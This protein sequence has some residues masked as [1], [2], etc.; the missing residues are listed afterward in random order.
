[1]Q[2]AAQS[3]MSLVE[4]DSLTPVDGLLMKL[5]FELEGDVFREPVFK[6]SDVRVNVE[7]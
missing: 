7:D 2:N 6:P 4:D 1:M 3:K 5:A